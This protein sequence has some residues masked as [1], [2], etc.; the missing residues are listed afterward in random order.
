[1]VCARHRWSALH[2]SPGIPTT[3]PFYSRE[4]ET[5]QK[6]VASQAHPAQGSEQQD[7][8]LGLLSTLP[9][10]TGNN[11]SLSALSSQKPHA[12]C[13]ALLP[14]STFIWDRR[15]VLAMLGSTQHS[16]LGP[17]QCSLDYDRE[18]GSWGKAGRPPPPPDPS[19]LRPPPPRADRRSR[20]LSTPPGSLVSPVPTASIKGPRVHISQQFWEV[21]GPCPHFP[22]WKRRLGEVQLL[23]RSRTA[24][25]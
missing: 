17:G 10:F 13:Q 19:Q 5:S 22:M 16:P 2:G 8:S 12:R 9:L 7:S 25:K 6:D 21:G 15:V 11:T 4:S 23:A 18:S 24:A 3:A 14:P 20:A 1:M